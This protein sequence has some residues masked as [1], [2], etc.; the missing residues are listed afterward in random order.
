VNHTNVILGPDG[1]RVEQHADIALAERRLAHFNALAGS[2]APEAA[3]EAEP[4]ALAPGMPALLEGTV[5]DVR[6]GLASGDY[7][8]VLADL[9]A[10]EGA[11]KQ[12]KGVLAALRARL[13]DR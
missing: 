1:V 2:P 13:E 7:D 8:G 10:Q 3:P 5:G 11:H 9:L 12:R 4:K 6:A